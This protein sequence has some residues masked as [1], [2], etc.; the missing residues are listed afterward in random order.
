MP[1]IDESPDPLELNISDE[2]L[3]FLIL[4]AREFDTEVDTDEPDP[5][6]NPIDDNDVEVLGDMPENSVEAELRDALAE[7]NEDETIDVIALVW[8]GR[9]DYTRDEWEE[10]RRLA[11]ER[12]RRDSTGYLMGNP[13]FADDLDEGA[14]A[15]GHDVTNIEAEHL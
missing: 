13:T 11:A 10:A 3:A 15:V 7:L 5:G 1:T 14:Q 9:G 2:K 12:H 6:S 8:V 4:K